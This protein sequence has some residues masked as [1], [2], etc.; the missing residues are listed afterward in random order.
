MGAPIPRITGV[1][2]IFQA[3]TVKRIFMDQVKRKMYVTLSSGEI[4]NGDSF[5]PDP[6][7]AV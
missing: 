6:A 2:E 7:K 1:V 3:S 5:H 4:G